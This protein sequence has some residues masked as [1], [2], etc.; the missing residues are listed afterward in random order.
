VYLQCLKRTG[1]YASHDR[2]ETWE[3]A[4]AADGVDG[5]AHHPKDETT[6]FISDGQHENYWSYQGSRPAKLL[7]STDAGK[8]WTPLAALDSGPLYIDPMKPD[9]MLMS[10]LHGGKGILRSTDGGQ[11]WHDFHH[12][13]PSYTARGFTFGGTP[14]SVIYHMFGNMARTTKL[15][16]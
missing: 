9:I 10:T 1:L 8:T 4:H 13:A 14:G 16:D 12:D 7:K 3:V 11:T 2:G 5:L 15:Y 6:L